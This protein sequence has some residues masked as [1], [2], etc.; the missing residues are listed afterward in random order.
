[1]TMV[2]KTWTRLIRLGIV[3]GMMILTHGVVY[4]NK[5]AQKAVTLEE[6]IEMALKDNWEI[7]LSKKNK[8]ASILSNKLSSFKLWA[9]KAGLTFSHGN[10]WEEKVTTCYIKSDP[11]FKLT[12]ELNALF[13]KVFE[14]KK[15]R[16]QNLI[17]DLVA[18]KAVAKVLQEVVTCYYEL[19]LAQKKW[20]ISNSFTKIATARLKT[21]QEK[22]KL[23]IASK[24]DL[25]HADLALKQAKLTVLEQQ[26]MLKEKRRNLN[27]VLNKSFDEEIRVE[28]SISVKPIW[29]IAAITKEKVI[30]L[31]TEIQEKKVGIAATELSR[32]KASPLSCLNLYGSIASQGYTYDVKKAKSSSTQ[33]SQSL[34]WGLSLDLG[35]LLCLPAEIK[36]AKIALDIEKST[37]TKEKLV[38]ESKLETKRWKYRHAIGLHKM[39]EE[40]LKLSKQKLIFIKEQ[41]RLN[42]VKLLDLQEAEQDVQKAEISLIEYAFKV[43]QAEFELYQLI[44]MFHK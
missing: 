25:L 16:K 1:M 20:D 15:L 39:V 28:S 19:A 11:V 5:S 36:R 29:D 6:V 14:T 13:D 2:I 33:P 35:S 24:I 43:K 12:W 4:A 17:A 42:Q 8:S 9:P 22:F 30:D 38:A 34:G 3:C 37:L 10:R 23:G 32:V 26:E 40:Q 18:V 44:G 41:Y 27:L 21:E 7:Q 31:E